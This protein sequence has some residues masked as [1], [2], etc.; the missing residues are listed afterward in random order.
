[1]LIVFPCLQEN[2]EICQKNMENT[3]LDNYETYHHQ[4]NQNGKML[5]VYPGRQLTTS[6]PLP[7][8]MGKRKGR[9]NQKTSW[10]TIKKNKIK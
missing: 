2:R 1:L 9:E 5:Q 7:L 6:Q 4:L 10:D 3:V 8:R